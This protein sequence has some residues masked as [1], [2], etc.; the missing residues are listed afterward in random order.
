LIGILAIALIV[1]GLISVLLDS[2]FRD[3]P[4]SAILPKRE[5]QNIIAQLPAAK[6]ERNKLVI[7]A[8]IDSHRTPLLFSSPFWVKVLK[9][10]YSGW[11]CRITFYLYSNSFFD[12]L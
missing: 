11:D 2:S 3:N 12:F 7:M 4:L 6:S 9:A 5:S 8:H 1:L 10:Y